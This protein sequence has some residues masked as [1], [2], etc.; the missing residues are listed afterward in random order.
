MNTL[1]TKKELDDK[2]Y[3]ENYYS[4]K[5]TPYKHSDFAQY[6]YT[7]FIPKKQYFKL[8]ELGCGNGR[9][10]LYFLSK[11]VNVVAVDQCESEI[12]YLSEKYS[13][14]NI[15][16]VAADFSR[17]G[18]MGKFDAIY[19]RFT[20]HAIDKES[21]IATLKW[22][23]KNINKKG[24]LFIEARGLKNEYF[25]LGEK[26]PFEKNTFYYENHN[27]RFI[28]LDAVVK[29][30]ESLDF[31]I[32]LADEQKDRAPFETQNHTFARII[33]KKYGV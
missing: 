8:I 20:L 17:L 15:R 7:N 24:W 11:G 22:A 30:L 2:S 13:N 5:S 1:L 26:H 31:E 21:E 14:E 27:R 32:I 33:A 29:L 16:F 4:K 10:A 23:S 18:N 28:D 6:C 19:S 12:K 9:D 3:W 25:G